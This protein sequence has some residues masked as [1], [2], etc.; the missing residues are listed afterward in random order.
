MIITSPRLVLRPWQRRDLDALADLPRY[1]DPL[2]DDWNW[3]H[4]LRA[5]GTADFFFLGRSCDPNRAEWTISLSSGQ[6]IGHIG[7]RDIER[8]QRSARLG[9]GLGS[10]YVGQ[11]YGHEALRTFLDSFFGPL[12]L[13]QM[14]LDVRAHNVRARRLYERLGFR[15]TSSYWQ[16]AGTREECAFLS[17]PRYDAIRDDFRLGQ[18]HVLVRCLAMSLRSADW[19]PGQQ[20]GPA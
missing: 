6:I 16:I 18:Q 20:Q 19:P 14:L 8:E 4:A 12:E 17:A 7:I 5:N 11:G 3:P 1:P 13:E 15:E 10:P 2:D 9:M